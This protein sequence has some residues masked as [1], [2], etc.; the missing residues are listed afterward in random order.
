VKE[1]QKVSI[2]DDRDGRS[3]AGIT[4]I[5]GDTLTLTPDRAPR[6]VV[7]YAQIVRIDRP[8]DTLATGALIGLGFGAALGFGAIAYEAHKPRTPNS[9]IFGDCSGTTGV[10]YIAGTLLAGALGS[11]VGVVVD[12]M[13]RRDRRIYRCGGKAQVGLSPVLA[14]GRR[15]AVL[16]MSW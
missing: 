13:I 6:V 5:A 7:P 3:T 10:S 4:T 16:S 14:R 2:T 8:H 11:A 9:S 1:R 15:G 12:A